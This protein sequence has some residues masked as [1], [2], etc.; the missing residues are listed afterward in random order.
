MAQSGMLALARDR[1]QWPDSARLDGARLRQLRLA[2]RWTQETLARRAGVAPG[3]VMRLERG[4]AAT[5]RCR[6]ATRLAQALGEEFTS[7]VAKAHGCSGYIAYCSEWRQSG[8]VVAD[9]AG[10]IVDLLTARLKG[11]C[12]DASLLRQTRWAVQPDARWREFLPRQ[13][14][15]PVLNNRQSQRGG[16]RNDTPDGDS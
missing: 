12:P 13:W 15:I 10:F 4:V 3:T 16:E 9:S 8:I 1:V 5:C 7:L 14:S 2:K 6:T 11:G